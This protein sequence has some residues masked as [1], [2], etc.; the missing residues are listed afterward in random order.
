MRMKGLRKGFNAGLDRLRDRGW[1]VLQTALAAG[2]AYFLAKYLLGHQQPTY[3]AVAAVITLGAAVGWAVN[4]AFQ[5]VVGVTAGLLVAEALVLFVIGSGSWQIAFVLALAMG[6]VV[7]FGGGPLLLT[8]I[9]ITVITVV[10]AVAPQ[11]GF[12][13]E[14][15]FDALMGIGVALVVGVLLPVDPEKRIVRTARP[16]LSDLAAILED[17]TAA[18]EGRDR[19]KAGD[20]LVEARQADERVDELRAAIEAARDTARLSPVRRRSLERLQTY[21]TVAEGLDLAVPNV[22]VLSRSALRLL[23]R[24]E[25]APRGLNAAVLNLSRAVR[26]LDSYL[27][28]C[29]QD[30]DDVRRYALAAARGATDVLDER[31]HFRISAL[32]GQ[33]RSTAVALLRS[34][35]MDYDLAIDALEE[36]AGD[37]PAD[38]PEPAHKADTG[39]KA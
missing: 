32:V 4:R 5:V 7:F 12:S 10:A 18:L 20:A 31:Q 30:T 29:A 21:V 19:D 36:A 17:A 25:P 3:A 1:P 15:V 24:G 28:G 33:I 2:L 6:A 9:A 13:L 35:S 11:Q 34:I 38:A 16:V 26:A 23:R 14:R 37:P 22:R 8:Q 27:G 39:R